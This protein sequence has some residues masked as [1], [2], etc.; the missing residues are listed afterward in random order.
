[1]NTNFKKEA[2]NT[3]NIMRLSAEEQKHISGGIA[4]NKLVSSGGSDLNCICKGSTCVACTTCIGLCKST[5][6]I[7][8]PAGAY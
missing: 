6:P 3:L 5:C 1:M 2:R 7:C 8:V 4:D